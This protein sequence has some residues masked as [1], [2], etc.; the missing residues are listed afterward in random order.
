VIGPG[1]LSELRIDNVQ[2]L[3]P[4]DRIDLVANEAL[5]LALD[6]EREIPLGKGARVSIQLRLDGPW[7]VDTR[8]VMDEMVAERLFDRPVSRGR[9]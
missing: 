6:G 1:L 3:H 7:L 9:S 5:V 4:G 8:R 2:I